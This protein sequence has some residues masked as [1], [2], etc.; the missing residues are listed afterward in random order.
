MSGSN[1]V[2]PLLHSKRIPKLRSKKQ[3]RTLTYV[4]LKTTHVFLAFSLLGFFGVGLI[5]ILDE[6]EAHLNEWKVRGEQQ[7]GSI[8]VK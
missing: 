6:G 2:D 3:L 1:L 5:V 8:Q 4:Y 7:K